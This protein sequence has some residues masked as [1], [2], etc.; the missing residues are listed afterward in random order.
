MGILMVSNTRRRSER[1]YMSHYRSSQHL[2]G[3]MHDFGLTRSLTHLFQSRRHPLQQQRCWQGS[4]RVLQLWSASAS[5]KNMSWVPC[6]LVATWMLPQSKGLLPIIMKLFLRR[7]HSLLQMRRDSAFC[8][9]LF[10]KVRTPTL[11]PGRQEPSE[12]PSSDLSCSRSGYWGRNP[13][14]LPS[15]YLQ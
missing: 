2:L 11:Q 10:S 7:K 15:Q 8:G 3:L 1:G 6:R 9:G 13:Q 14:H 5:S 12:A 4:C